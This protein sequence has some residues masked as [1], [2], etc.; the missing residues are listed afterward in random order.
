[1]PRGN[2]RREAPQTDLPP[3]LD[4]PTMKPI[5]V[6]L[7]FAFVGSIVCMV[8]HSSFRSPQTDAAE[9]NAP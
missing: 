4:D 8:A 3:R 5:G 6:F 2:H 1:M 9:E 7:L